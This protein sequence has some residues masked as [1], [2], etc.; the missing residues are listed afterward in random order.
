MLIQIHIL[1]NYAPANLNRDDTGAPKDAFFGGYRRG[2]ISSQCLKR[3]IRKSEVFAAA[4]A[5][6]GLL[7][8]RTKKLH[9]LLAAEL[10]HMNVDDDARSDILARV[11]EIG[12]ESRKA[13]A[14]EETEEGGDA[15][16]SVAT[17]V[18]T[19][20]L[21]FIG[22]DEIPRLAAALL[23]LYRRHGPKEW[24]DPKKLKIDR[25]TAELKSEALPRSVDIALFGRMT[26]SEAFE[27]VHAAVQV[28]HAL[29]THALAQEFDY[30]TAIDDLS[31]EPGAGMI[32]D[33]EFNSSTYYRYLNLHWEQLLD[34]LGQDRAVA[35]R[36]ALALLQAAATA[37]PTGKQNSFA[38][39]NLPDLVLVEI[40]PSNLGVSY[41]NAFV[42]PARATAETSLVEASVNALTDYMQRVNA[43]YDVQAERCFASTG[44]WCLAGA[45]RAS[46]LA[47]LAKW[48]EMQLQEV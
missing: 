16:P 47:A 11:A 33:V 6:D 20:Q 15:E 31:T 46:S 4:F 30:Y 41:A 10:V 9:Q 39:L 3:S 34:N 25:I 17:E 18:D 44:D 19:K 27:D 12:R 35:R 21:I 43:L 38:A 22:C 7:G 23:D 37:Q 32:G 40:S 48:L 36:A 5:A 13:P 2:R 42:R 14:Q 45:E 8:T 24:N 28:A 26:T 1:Q 29:S